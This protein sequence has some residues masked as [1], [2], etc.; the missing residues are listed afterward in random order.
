MPNTQQIQI[1]YYYGQNDMRKLLCIALLL[2]ATTVMAQELQLPP[3]PITLAQVDSGGRIVSARSEDRTRT[4]TVDGQAVAEN[5]QVQLQ[6]SHDAA[7]I[8]A[9]RLTASGTLKPAAIPSG[10]HAAVLVTADSVTYLKKLLRPNAL[11]LVEKSNDASLKTGTPSVAKPGKPP[12]SSEVLFAAMGG[13]PVITYTVPRIEQ[14]TRTSDG[15]TSVYTVR[16][17]EI[18]QMTADNVQCYALGE[19]GQVTPC[20][21][22]SNYGPVVYV[23][24]K[25]ALGFLGKL[26]QP[27]TIVFTKKQGQD[28]PR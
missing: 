11:V 28:G 9:H 4:K 24:A 12:G 13:G 22:P 26:L 1:P 14:R 8:E 19:N 27:G 6:Q 7:L 3:S 25:S 17:N 23:H 5:F 20:D 15:R 21:R 2:Q 16:V 10:S 18:R